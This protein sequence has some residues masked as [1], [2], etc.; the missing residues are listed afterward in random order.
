MIDLMFGVPPPILLPFKPRP[1]FFLNL[2]ISMFN[3]IFG[4]LSY[5]VNL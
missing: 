1:L 4:L 3:G 2:S 5:P